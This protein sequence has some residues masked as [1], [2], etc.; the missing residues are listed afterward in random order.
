[1]IKKICT[2]EASESKYNIYEKTKMFNI[3]T[4]HEIFKRLVTCLYYYEKYKNID[5]SAES[6]TTFCASDAYKDISIEYEE[7]YYKMLN[8]TVEDRQI[9]EIW[10]KTVYKLNISQQLTTPIKE[11]Q[12]TTIKFNIWTG[13]NP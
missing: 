7:K 4:V 9:F 6:F 11:K 5:M 13:V 2:G 8:I 12:T 1:M 3:P 10:N